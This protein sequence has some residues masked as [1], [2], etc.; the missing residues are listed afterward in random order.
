LGAPVF[1]GTG[2]LVGVVAGVRSGD[3]PTLRISLLHRLSGVLPADVRR[4][5]GVGR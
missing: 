5:L 1:D 2:A 4:R 3:A